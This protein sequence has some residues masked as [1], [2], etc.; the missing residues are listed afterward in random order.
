MRSLH[1]NRYSSRRRGR[2]VPR[3]SWVGGATLL[4]C[5]AGAAGVHAQDDGRSVSLTIYNQDL[6]VIR[7]ER[8]MTLPSGTDWLRFR[9]V[10]ERIDPTSVHLSAVDGSELAVLEQNYVYDLVSPEKILDRYLERR[11]Q[12][13]TEDGRL[14]E[15]TLL[16][17]SGGRLLLGDAAGQDGVT[18]LMTDK[19]TDLQFPELPEGLITHP[20]LEWLIDGGRGGDRRLEVSY[21]TQGLAWHAEYV[22]V[23]DD[24]DESLGLS[25]W[26]SIENRSGATFPE[27]ELQLVAGEPHRVQPPAPRGRLY[28][29]AERADKMMQAPF[30]EEAFFE[31]HLY[32]L[33]R[34]STIKN[35]E[36]KQLTLFAPARAVVEKKYEANPRR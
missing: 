20:T 24:Q 18:I 6:A 29:A 14:Y 3:R 13:V 25:G 16:S 5:A 28:A 1:P 21:M 27:A 36:T 15:G 4:L 33:S 12:A 9:D 11:I 23:V 7:D 17:H 10:P 2:T 19:I 30:A 31:Y 34:P 8:T 32:T 35:N 26:V 22:A